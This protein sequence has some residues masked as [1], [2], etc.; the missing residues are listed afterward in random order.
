MKQ[1][2][3]KQ[4]VSSK[5]LLMLSF[6]NLKYSLVGPP[7]SAPSSPTTVMI[8][9]HTSSFFLGSKIALSILGRVS[10]NT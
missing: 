3:L 5:Y 8:L 2:C 7:T 9:I 1:S 4:S 10:G 6:N